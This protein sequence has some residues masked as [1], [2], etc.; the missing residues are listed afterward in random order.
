M[1]QKTLRMV[2]ELNKLIT[3]ELLTAGGIYLPEIGSLSVEQTAEAS[4]RRTVV[5]SEVERHT[6]LV[7]VVAL[8][9]KCSVD[10]SSELYAKWLDAVKQ[11]LQIEIEGIGILRGGRFEVSS[12]IES[13]LNPIPAMEIKGDKTAKEPKAKPVATP[14]IETPSKSNNSRRGYMVIAVIV[15]AAIVFA[16]NRL[17]FKDNGAQVKESEVIPMVEL[18]PAKPITTTKEQVVTTKEVKP[19]AAVAAEPEPA[20]EVAAAPKKSSVGELT[21]RKAKQTP[22]S[23]ATE[24]LNKTMAASQDRPATKYKVVYGV[25]RSKSNAGRAIVDVEEQNQDPA[26]VCGVTLRDGNYMVTLFESDHFYTSVSFMKRNDQYF[27]NAL[28]VYDPEKM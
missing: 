19:E 4:A 18:T 27:S 7:V 26:M 16:A 12:V 24:I 17:V 1:E 10:Q 3:N 28:W 13:R 15:V 9:T 8:L 25:Y 21:S 5:Y 20:E 14:K 23:E 6:S 11:N 22:N 2:A